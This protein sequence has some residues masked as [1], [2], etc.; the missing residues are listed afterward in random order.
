M[1]LPT[2]KD[3]RRIL[4]RLFNGID[5]TITRSQFKQVAREMG[6][7]AGSDLGKV[8]REAAMAPVR[9]CISTAARSARSSLDDPATAAKE[10]LLRG[11][12][13]IRPVTHQDLQ[14]AINF[15][16][17][18]KWLDHKSDDDSSDDESCDQDEDEDCEH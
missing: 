8:A 15:V 2:E 18:E 4:K 13:A 12:E 5:H 7:W 3:R 1:G 10:M 11:F 17:P 6:D 16:A 9:E 14:R